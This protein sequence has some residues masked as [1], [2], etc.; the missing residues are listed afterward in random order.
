MTEKEAQIE[1]LE[2]LLRGACRSIYRLTAHL[3]QEEMSAAWGPEVLRYWMEQDEYTDE[4]ARRVLLSLPDE[5]IKAL[6]L[7]L[8]RHG[9]LPVE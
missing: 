7:F 9:E 1:H 3:S 2:R 5:D 6:N 8:D 4:R